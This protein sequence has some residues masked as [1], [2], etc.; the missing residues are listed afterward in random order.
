MISKTTEIIVIILAIFFGV[1]I[2]I[3]MLF[4]CTR[5]QKRIQD[6][7]FRHGHDNHSAHE[8]NQRYF[9][10]VGWFQRYRRKSR[11][12]QIDDV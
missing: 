3:L 8:S 1:A 6:D 2:F 12:D 4:Y 11:Y 5:H 9:G 7:S 10:A